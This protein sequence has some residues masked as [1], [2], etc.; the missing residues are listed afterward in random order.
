[1]AAQL[2]SGQGFKEVY[3]LKGGIKA[4]NGMKAVGPAELGMAL[5]TG[6]ESLPYSQD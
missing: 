1:M 3:N 2:L 6:K 5:I 4:W